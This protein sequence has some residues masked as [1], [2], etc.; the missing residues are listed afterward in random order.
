MANHRSADQ[1]HTIFSE[2]HQSGLSITAF[3]LQQCITTSNFY[4]WRKKLDV[5]TQQITPSSSDWH[6]VEPLVPPITPKSEP[7]WDL[8]L[9]LP[10]GTVLRLRH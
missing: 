3:C 5:A 4:A 2:F 7:S 9:T 6:S 8:E 1:W 10:G